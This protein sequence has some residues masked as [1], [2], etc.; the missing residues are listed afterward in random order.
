LAKGRPL[1]LG[2]WPLAQLK[3]APALLFGTTKALTAENAEIAEKRTISRRFTRMEREESNWQLQLAQVEPV[4]AVLAGVRFVV[5]DAAKNLPGR[6]GD[7]EKTR[8]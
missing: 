5:W 6:H 4:L 3:P 7:T 2:L 8:F 1:V